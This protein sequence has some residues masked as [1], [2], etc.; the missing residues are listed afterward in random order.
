MEKPNYEAEPMVLGGKK[1]WHIGK[2]EEGKEVFAFKGGYLKIKNGEI[3]TGKEIDEHGNF[4]EKGA[5]KA[6]G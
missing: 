3:E 5:E 1:C 2:D 4:A 6:D